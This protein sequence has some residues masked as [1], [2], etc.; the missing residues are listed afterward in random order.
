MSVSLSPEIRVRWRC[1]SCWT[2]LNAPATSRGQTIPCPNCKQPTIIE[3]PVVDGRP[4]RDRF[5]EDRI[6][7]DQQLIEILFAI[8]D[9]QTE[10]SRYLNFL[11][12]VVKCLLIVWC[13]GIAIACVYAFCLVWE[14]AQS[15]QHL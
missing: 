14:T 8:L 7:A 12:R 9:Q 1:P 13:I 11:R 6:P 10:Q 4:L 15:T 3:G 5:A 2:D